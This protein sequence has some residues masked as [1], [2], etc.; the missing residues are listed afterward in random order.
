MDPLKFM[1]VVLVGQAWLGFIKITLLQYLPSTLDE[2]AV[3]SAVRPIFV[4][5]SDG[6]FRSILISADVFFTLEL[7][8]NRSSCVRLVDIHVQL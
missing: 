4:D 7:C 6:Y 3:D 5:V 2:S 1:L 8:A